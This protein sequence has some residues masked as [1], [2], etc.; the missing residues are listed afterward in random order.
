MK[1]EMKS[2]FRAYLRARIYPKQSTLDFHILET[3]V[4]PFLNILEQELLNKPFRQQYGCPG[5]ATILFRKFLENQFAET[6][7]GRLGPINGPFRSAYII[8]L[9]YFLWVA[10]EQKVFSNDLPHDREILEERIQKAIKELNELHTIC[11]MSDEYI[12]RAE[13]CICRNPQNMR[14]LEQAFDRW[15]HI[16]CNRAIS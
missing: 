5:H 3:L 15:N 8:P 14:L 12:I 13:K 6:K 1:L 9:E 16:S 11:K 10:V 7:I 2:H 4:L